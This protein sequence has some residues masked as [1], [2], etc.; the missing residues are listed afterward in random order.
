MKFTT[1]FFI[2]SCL[3]TLSAQDMTIPLYPEG[4]PCENDLSQE[5][6]EVGSTGRRISKVHEPSISVFLAPTHVANGTSILI[7]PGG[8][9]TVLAWDWEGTRMAEW[10]NRMG[11]S[12][13]VLKYRLPHWESPECRGKVALMDA[14][15]AMR[16]IRSRAGSFQLDP[17]R[18]GVMGFSAGGHLASTLST[19][20]DQRESDAAQMVDMYPCRPDFSILM[21]PVVSMD[22]T[23]GHRGSGRNLLGDHPSKEMQLYYS[24]EKQITNET[25]PTILI[26]ASDDLSVPAEN[27][28]VY[29]QALI[30]HD[31]SAAMHIYHSGGHGFSFAEDMGAVSGWPTACEAWMREQGLLNPKMR[32]LI[33][34]GQNNHKNWMETTPILQSHLQETGLFQ[35]DV[36]RTPAT[37][38]S[39]ENF[40]PDFGRYDLVVS[41]YNGDEWPDV[42]KNNFERFIAAGGGLV[43]VHAADNAFASW[44]AYNEMIGL[45]GWEDRTEAHGPYVYFDKNGELIRDTTAGKGGHHGEKHEFMVQIRDRQHP[46]T[47]GLPERWMHV[48]DELYDQLRGPASNLNILATAY[49]DPAT[50]GTGRHEPILMS[51]RYGQGRIFHT[52]LGHLNESMQGLG[53]KITLQRGAEWAA[54]GV[55][56]QPIPLVLPSPDEVRSAN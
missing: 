49:S 11:V 13:F 32:A 8:G 35:V 43:S 12:A 26:H 2:G 19:H 47:S 20:F 56:S 4:I 37:G 7:C 10:Y 33:I 14:Q 38:K 50:K 30:K 1:L 27:S 24:N 54:S 28:I 41:N 29:Y 51:I 55:V 31:V 52:T 3:L 17:N 48:K 39:M 18:V 46:I 22:T 23:F 21:Y 5:V 42:T 25:P 40:R 34:E 45:G 36:V 16:L 6:W 9:Y 44:R 15:R 53:F